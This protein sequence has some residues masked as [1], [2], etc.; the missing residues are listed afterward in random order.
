MSLGTPGDVTKV[1]AY[2]LSVDGAPESI[3]YKAMMVNTI[4]DSSQLSKDH[5][6]DELYGSFVIKPAASL[7]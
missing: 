1:S 5:Q 2:E 6:S 4:V 7:S 3:E